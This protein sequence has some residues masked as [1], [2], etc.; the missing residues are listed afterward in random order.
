M[1]FPPGYLFTV[2]LSAQG[3]FYLIQNSTCI[4]EYLHVSVFLPV[5]HVTLGIDFVLFS[6]IISKDV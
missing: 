1:Y 3:I 5:I 6:P 2:F 4:I